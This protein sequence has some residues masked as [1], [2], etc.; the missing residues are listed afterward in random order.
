MYAKKCMHD[1]IEKLIQRHQEWIKALL[2][3]C[4]ICLALIKLKLLHSLEPFQ[5]QQCH[6]VEVGGAW[7]CPTAPLVR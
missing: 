6:S 1:N 5:S 2:M 4:M 7:E 3:S